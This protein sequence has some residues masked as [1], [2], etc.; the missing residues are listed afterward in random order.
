[1]VVAKGFA[2]VDVAE[3]VLEAEQSSNKVVPVENDDADPEERNERGEQAGEEGRMK[4]SACV[5][6]ETQDEAGIR[7]ARSWTHRSRLR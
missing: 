2:E 3:R 4:D 1:M 5:T 6:K 7:T